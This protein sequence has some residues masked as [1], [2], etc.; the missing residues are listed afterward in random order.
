MTAAGYLG[1][2][3]IRKIRISPDSEINMRNDE[4]SHNGISGLGKLVHKIG[5]NNVLAQ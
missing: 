2:I 1:T 3:R 4:E 5:E